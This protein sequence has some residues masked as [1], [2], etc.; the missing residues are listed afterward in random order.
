[1]VSTLYTKSVIHFPKL[2]TVL[3][4]EDFIKDH[5]GEFKKKKIWESLPRGVMYQT[6]CII[7]NYLIES[8]KIARDSENKIAWIWN[9]KL[10]EKYLSKPNLMW[11]K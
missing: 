2:D 9:P 4:V 7:F 8:K 1:M 10:V 3:M 5:S 11:K 6:F